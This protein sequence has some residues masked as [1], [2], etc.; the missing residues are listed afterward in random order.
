MHGGHLD[1]RHGHGVEVGAGGNR[2]WLMDLRRVLEFVLDLQGVVHRREGEK[3]GRV[4]VMIDRC[5]RLLLRSLSV[6][7]QHFVT[8]GAADRARGTSL[9]I[10]ALNLA[11]ALRGN[12]GVASSNLGRGYQGPS[13]KPRIP[14]GSSRREPLGG[15]DGGRE[16]GW[17]PRVVSCSV[18]SRSDVV[19][20][21]S[22][23][24]SSGVCVKG[25]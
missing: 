13:C 12:V 9:R 20:G 11:E 22:T 2:L 23:P 1:K 10:E 8:A 17:G 25:F 16:E 21:S 14:L 15:E 5:S 6:H 19:E 4:C 3:G 18:D 24:L 7:W